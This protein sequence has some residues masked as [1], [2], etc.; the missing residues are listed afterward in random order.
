MFVTHDIDESVYLADRVIVLSKAPSHVIAEIDV[1][2]T[3]PRDQVDTKATQEFV[4]L[5]AEV[6]RLIRDQGMQGTGEG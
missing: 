2:I 4:D 1:S 5:R 3:R 6:A